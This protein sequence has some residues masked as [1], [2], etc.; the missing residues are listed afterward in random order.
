MPFFLGFVSVSS[1]R[2]TSSKVSSSVVGGGFSKLLER[3]PGDVMWQ[4]RESRD[5]RDGAASGW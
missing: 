4:K 2:P 5:V 1:V 3:M